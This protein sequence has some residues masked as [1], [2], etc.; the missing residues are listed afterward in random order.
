MLL[1]C[2]CL[3][4]ESCGN[5]CFMIQIKPFINLPMLCRK[6]KRKQWSLAVCNSQT[7][8][9]TGNSYW[10]KENYLYMS[11]DDS[12]LRLGICQMSMKSGLIE[13]L[14]NNASLLYHQPGSTMFA[15]FLI[16]TWRCGHRHMNP[17][18]LQATC[19]PLP[20]NMNTIAKISR[21]STKMQLKNHRTKTEKFL[22]K[23][24][25]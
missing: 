14:L 1:W 2:Y 7:A 11:R 23:L 17:A 22:M 18:A 4:S 24:L 21:I 25:W 5:C 10:L 15:C 19:I 3:H 12:R 20:F 16:S 8:S 9:A 13:R 6:S